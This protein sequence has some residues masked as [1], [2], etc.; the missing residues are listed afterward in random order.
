MKAGRDNRLVKQYL[1]LGTPIY[2]GSYVEIIS[3][4]TAED[5]IAFPY[6]ADVKEGVRTLLDGTEG[7]ALPR[8]RSGNAPAAESGLEDGTASGGA[9]ISVGTMDGA[10]YY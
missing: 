4:L 1:E 3:G 8:G 7:S 6:G 5:Y 9:G 2:S 10:V